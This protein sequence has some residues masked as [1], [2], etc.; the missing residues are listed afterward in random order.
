MLKK[1]TLICLLL[2]CFGA[3]VGAYLYFK[4]SKNYRNTK[5][6]I[7]ITASELIYD[8]SKNESAAGLKYLNKIVQVTGMVQDISTDESGITDINLFA[9]NEAAMISCA[10]DS[11]ERKNYNNVI[12]G[13]EVTIKGQCTG[14]LMDVVMIKCVIVK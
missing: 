1:I 7:K 5:A 11:S 14:M 10:M 6:D 9:K 8:F 3:S 2:I 12:K 4:P 13:S